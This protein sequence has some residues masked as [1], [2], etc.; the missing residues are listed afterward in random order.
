MKHA[1]AIK[2]QDDYISDYALVGEGLGVVPSLMRQAIFKCA[3]DPSYVRK[4]DEESAIF[5]RFLEKN[6]VHDVRYRFHEY[7]FDMVT[8]RDP[9]CHRLRVPA[10]ENDRIFNDDGSFVSE[11]VR[12][13]IREE[14]V[15]RNVYGPV[16]LIS[17]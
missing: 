4:L 12:S 17:P 6:G 15:R 16:L 11:N 14:G 5:D 3:V 13:S 7:F 8:G 1:L 10:D 9:T 2:D